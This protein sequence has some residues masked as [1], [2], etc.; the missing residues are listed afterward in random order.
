MGL[1]TIIVLKSHITPRTGKEDHNG[2][3][4]VADIL[5]LLREPLELRPHAHQVH[6]CTEIVIM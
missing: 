5:L 2:T 1:S 6:E 4:R 3:N